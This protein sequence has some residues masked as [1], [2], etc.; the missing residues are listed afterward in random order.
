MLAPLAAELRAAEA[1]GEL[2]VPIRE[3]AR[4]YLHMTNIR[5]LRTAPRAHELVIYE[6]LARLTGSR[7]ARCRRNKRPD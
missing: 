3:L 5:L 7:L 4:S 2:G 1:R 6:F